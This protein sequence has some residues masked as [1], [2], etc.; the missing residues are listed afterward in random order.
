MDLLNPAST[1]AQRVDAVFLW[2]VGLS[3]AFLVFITMLMLGFTLRY[4]RSRHPV[5]AQIEGHTGLEILWTVVP[6]VLFLVIFYYGWTNFDYMR[7]APRDALVVKV[8]ARQWAWSFEYPNGR[9]TPVLYAPAGRPVKLEVRALDVIHGLYIAPFRIKIDAVPGMVNTTWFRALRTGA[10]DLQCTVICG[11]GHS[12]MLTQ[13]VVVPEADFRAWYFGK[14]DAPPPKVP[15]ADGQPPGSA[16][17]PGTPQGQGG[18][19]G[20][21]GPGGRGRAAGLRLLEERACLAC[22]SLDGSPR[23]GPTFKGL[24]GRTETIRARDGARTVVLD[25]A[26][27]RRAIRKPGD[28]RV[29]GYP[30]SM[31]PAVL[32]DA[33][34]D[35]V[36]AFLRGLR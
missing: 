6:L 16:G 20:P 10:Y 30:P 14:E 15:A 36:V 24:F 27:V 3:V 35:Q 29:A 22:H 8:T 11:A 21:G 13:V 28:E 7:N 9:Q 1:S 34:L 19:G 31:P 32:D 17:A 2:T 12:L 33:E 23:V 5:A 18:Q 26:Q 4:R 25:E